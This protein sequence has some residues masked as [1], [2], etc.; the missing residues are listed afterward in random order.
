M[1][2]CDFL[3]LSLKQIFPEDDKARLYRLNSDQQWVLLGFLLKL[4]CFAQFHGFRGYQYVNSY[5][6]SEAEIDYVDSLA[7]EV[8]SVVYNVNNMSNMLWLIKLLSNG[9][10]ELQADMAHWLLSEVTQLQLDRFAHPRIFILL[11]K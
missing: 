10:I 11:F 7:D 8:R 4:A 6:S 2:S 9:R 1:R 3:I 5:I